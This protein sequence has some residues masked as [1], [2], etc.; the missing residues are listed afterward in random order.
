M[1]PLRIAMFVDGFPVITETFILNQITGLLDR[2]HAVDIFARHPQSP[3]HVH[4]DIER[5]RLLDRTSYL[6]RSPKKQGR[7]SAVMSLLWSRAWLKPGALRALVKIL[8]GRRG[9]IPGFNK[10]GMLRIARREAE[11]GPYDVI[12]CQYGTLGRKLSALR[13]ARVIHGVLVTS[14]RGHDL[15]QADKVEHGYY[16]DLFQRGDLFLPVSASLARKLGELNCPSQKVVVHHSG[17]DLTQF[18]FRERCRAPNAPTMVVTVSRLI[19]MKGIEFGIDAVARLVARGEPIE[20]HVIGDGPLRDSLEAK[21]RGLGLTDHIQLHG[22]L[23]HDRVLQHVNDA[24]LMLHP[25]ITAS[26]G[27][28]EGIPNAVKEGMAM[29]L[30]VIATRHAG[31]PELVEDGISGLLVPERDVTALSE[32]LAALC[33]NPDRWPA[34]GRAGRARIEAEY[35]R[36]RLN[37]DLVCLYRGRVPEAESAEPSP[38]A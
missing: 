36:N 11:N 24:H 27:E 25:S 26:N 15:T 13:D 23:P 17:I 28:A 35:D 5:Y 31:V 21:I 22:P 1:H 6:E 29:G 37:D 3:A 10:K 18:P 7:L 8:S 4:R 34:M 14:F 30:P 16:E 33:S 20:Y 12:H 19:E 38:V 32:C 9:Q 2:G